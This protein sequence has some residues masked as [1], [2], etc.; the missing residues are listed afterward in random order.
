MLLCYQTRDGKMDRASKMYER[1]N[2]YDIL[3]RK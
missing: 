3:I 2:V 1:E